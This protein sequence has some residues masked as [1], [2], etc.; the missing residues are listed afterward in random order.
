MTRGKSRLLYKLETASRARPRADLAAQRPGPAGQSLLRCCSRWRARH[1]F[2]AQLIGF[3]RVETGLRLARTGD[4]DFYA[5][6]RRRVCLARFHSGPNPPFKPPHATRL[7]GA[8]RWCSWSQARRR[9]RHRQAG[10][11]QG[12]RSARSRSDAAST[13]CLGARESRAPAGGAQSFTLP[14]APTALAID[15][16]LLRSAP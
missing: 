1:R 2:L 4:F 10:G 3:V 16:D 11:G 7:L 12:Q 9:I 6:M 15:D 8:I 5:P 14:N 13:S